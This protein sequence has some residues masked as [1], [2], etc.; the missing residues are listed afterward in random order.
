V[1]TPPRP[2]VDQRLGFG[3]LLLGNTALGVRERGDGVSCLKGIFS[4][5]TAYEYRCLVRVARRIVPRTNVWSDVWI[6]RA[7]SFFAWKSY[8]GSLVAGMRLLST[9]ERKIGTGEPRLD[10]RNLQTKHEAL[11][12]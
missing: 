2:H 10:I 12:C 8:K 6:R 3:S 11:R 1:D 5:C 7:I 9:P 4:A